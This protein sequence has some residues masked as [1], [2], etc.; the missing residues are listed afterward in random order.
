[1]HQTSLTNHTHTERTIRRLRLLVV[2][3]VVSNLV[4]GFLSA[5]LL[6]RLDRDYSELLDETWPTVQH[7]RTVGQE[8]TNAYKQ[9]VAGLA[10]SDPARCAAYVKTIDATMARIRAGRV[11][12][13]QSELLAEQPPLLADYKTAAAEFDAGVAGIMP[14]LTPASTVESERGALD[15]FEASLDRVRTVNQKLLTFIETR[16]QSISG[17]FSAGVRQRSF[18]VL[19]VAAWPVLIAAIAVV[20]T[21]VVVLAMLF[22][23]RRSGDSV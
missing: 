8:S 7:V 4:L 13:V 16:S 3:L 23:F 19:S 1:M 22:M 15:K 20:S 6:R 18:L 5:Y 2:A 9:I 21:L 17:D 12:V 10:E 11:L 14:R